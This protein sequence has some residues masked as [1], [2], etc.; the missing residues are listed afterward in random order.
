MLWKRELRLRQ[1]TFVPNSS[2]TLLFSPPKLSNKKAHLLKGTHSVSRKSENCS[3][4]EEF[5]II[6]VQHPEKQ[7]ILPDFRFYTSRKYSMPATVLGFSMMKRKG[8]NWAISIEV[9]KSFSAMWINGRT[10]FHIE[11][12]VSY[13][14]THTCPFDS[15]SMISFLSVQTQFSGRVVF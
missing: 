9:M 6:Y 13:L 4:P 1:S 12:Q 8:R 3:D 11:A 2:T 15:I 7:V 5:S 10:K 14:Y